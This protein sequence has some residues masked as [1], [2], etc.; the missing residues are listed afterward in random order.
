M[1][2]FEERS[3]GS[4]I[5]ARPRLLGPAQQDE[6][7]A[8]QSKGNLFP[9]GRLGRVPEALQDQVVLGNLAY[10]HFLL[11]DHEQARLTLSEAIRLAS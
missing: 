1:R 8:I 4:L 2:L 11:G 7:D 10:L 5:F 9:Q 3:S 6:A